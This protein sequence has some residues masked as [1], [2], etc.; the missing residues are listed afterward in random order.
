M[1]RLLCIAAISSL[2]LSAVAERPAGMLSGAFASQPDPYDDT[3]GDVIYND[4]ITTAVSFDSADGAGPKRRGTGVYIRVNGGFVSAQ[5]HGDFD[6]AAYPNVSVFNPPLGLL[7]P[8]YAQ[9][10]I[11]F[12]VGGALGVRIPWRSGYGHGG[13]TRLEAE[14]MFRT[15]TLD[16]VVYDEDFGVRPEADITGRVTSHAVMGNIIAEWQ[17]NPYWRFGFGGG[18][19]VLFSDLKANGEEGDGS[20]FAAQALATA[21]FRM[22]DNLWLTFGARVL[23]AAEVEYGTDIEEASTFAGDLTVGISLE[24]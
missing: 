19:G 16:E 11:G 3:S 4:S 22:T 13:A 23:G 17:P 20:A 14:Y 6:P 5:H 1:R 9:S 18:A 10:D 8:E 12:A 7:E 15:Y 2:A 24:I 21:E